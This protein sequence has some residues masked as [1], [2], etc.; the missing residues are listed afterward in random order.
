[1]KF[2]LLPLLAIVHLL[3][4][5]CEMGAK[6]FGWLNDEGLDWYISKDKE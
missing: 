5:L 6:I 4:R 3:M 1:M 2:L